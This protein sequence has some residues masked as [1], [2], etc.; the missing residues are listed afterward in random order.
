MIALIKQ[1]KIPRRLE[2]ILKQGFVDTGQ[3][4]IGYPIYTNG[5]EALIYDPIADEKIISFIN[6][7]NGKYKLT[8]LQND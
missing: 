2:E 6:M 5:E 8:R 4:C 1:P 7:G 3:H